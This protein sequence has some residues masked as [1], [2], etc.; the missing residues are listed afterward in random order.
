M[1]EGK[2]CYSY[3]LSWKV[4]SDYKKGEK[5]IKEAKNVLNQNKQLVTHDTSLRGKHIRRPRLD[6]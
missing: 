4:E 3:A 2:T 6:S 5:K 1:A